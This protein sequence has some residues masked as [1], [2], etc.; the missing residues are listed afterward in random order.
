MNSV[1]GKK[2][3]GTQHYDVEKKDRSVLAGHVWRTRATTSGRGQI[4]PTEHT[5]KP[6]ICGFIMNT[7]PIEEL[8]FAFDRGTRY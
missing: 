2:Q 6:H 4:L 1:V 8:N 5:M 3:M 7:L